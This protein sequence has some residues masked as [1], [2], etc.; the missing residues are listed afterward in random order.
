MTTGTELTVRSPNTVTTEIDRG[1]TSLKVPW[2]MRIDEHPSWSMLAELR[3]TIRAG[4]ALNH[5][6]VRDLLALKEGQVF[7][8]I[9][10]ATEDVLVRMGKV[11]LGW[12][13][14][15]V[16]ERRLALRL[17]RLG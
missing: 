11:Q 7:E 12:S 8:S 5:F 13:E 14:F 9:S 4:V 3:V 2:M 16:L 6:K 15:E 1:N 10:P 17:T